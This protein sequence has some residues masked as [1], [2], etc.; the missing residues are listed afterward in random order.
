MTNW[1]PRNWP[2]SN[3]NETDVT[4]VA[5]A[6]QTLAIKLSCDQRLRKLWHNKY[7]VGW[8]AE[9]LTQSQKTHD[10]DKITIKS[11]WETKDYK[12]NGEKIRLK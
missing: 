3:T 4:A 2:G 10:D 7:N 6:W 1:E 5:Y 12:L 9:Q 8:Q 11:E